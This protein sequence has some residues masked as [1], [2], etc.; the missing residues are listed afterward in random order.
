MMAKSNPFKRTAPAKKAVPQTTAEAEQAVAQYGS[1]V[2]ERLRLEGKLKAEMAEL[3]A[4]YMEKIRPHKEAEDDL[5]EGL[6]TWA[7]GNRTEICKGGA[8]TVQLG[9]GVVGWRLGTEKVTF[10]NSKLLIPL[11]KA[12]KLLSWVRTKE[13]VDKDEILKSMKDPKMAKLFSDRAHVAGI[14]GL[15]IEQEEKFRVEPLGVDMAKLA[16]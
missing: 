13:E 2:A 16:S 6:Q 15:K 5:Y 9:T 3:S 10:K 12:K 11:L 4:Q 1:E 14:E 8:K 7:E